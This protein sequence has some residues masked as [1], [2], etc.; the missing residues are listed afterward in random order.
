M[1]LPDTISTLASLHDA[2]ASVAQAVVQLLPFGSRAAIEDLGIV[3]AGQVVDREGRTSLCLTSFGYEVIEAAARL[4]D[5]D[6]AG[7]LALAAR[8]DAA[9]TA[10]ADDNH[11]VS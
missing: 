3:S 2:P 7:V 4:E 11:R 8:W 10:D 5:S 6:P 9:T 1:L